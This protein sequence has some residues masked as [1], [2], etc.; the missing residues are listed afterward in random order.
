MHKERLAALVR[1][2]VA[3]AL[4]LLVGA[5]AIWATGHSVIE[6]YTALWSGAFGNKTYIGSTLA[7]SGT[8][9][10]AA[11]AVVV[12]FRAGALNLGG[13]G[14]L[15]LGGLVAALTALYLPVPAWLGIPAALLAGALAGALWALLPAWLEVRF[16]V[17]LLIGSL[18]LN[19][20][21]TLLAGYLVSVPFRDRTGGG[22][23]AQT[24]MIPKALQFAPLITGTRLHLGLAIT[25]VLA[26]VIWFVLMR[27]VTGYEWRMTGLNPHF[28]AYG[29]VDRVKGLLTAML[30]S[31]AIAGLGGAIEVLAIHHRFIDGSL[32]RPGFAWSGVMA[33]LLAENHPLAALLTALLLGAIQIGSTG[34]ERTTEIPLEISSVVQA[35]IVLFVSARIGMSWLQRTRGRREQ[36]G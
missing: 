29:G 18:L 31:G 1:P 32:T 11:L 21:G 30:T 23:L 22:A 8:I 34:M 16:Q 36:H 26:V 4:G 20:V 24:P 25:V 6:S 5:V 33:A 14:Q 15:V 28:A 17:S 7:R 35:V 27:T 3:I 2:L 9:A 19:Y 12:A 13:E 10:M